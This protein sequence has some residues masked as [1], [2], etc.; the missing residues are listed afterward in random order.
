VWV[1][2]EAQVRGRLDDGSRWSVAVLE[3]LLVI[4]QPDVGRVT[5]ADPP[6]GEEHLS[7]LVENEWN[8]T[9]LDFG[10][11]LAAGPPAEGEPW[12]LW[13]GAP[14]AD[15][16]TGTIALFRGA[17]TAGSEPDLVLEANSPGDRLGTVIARCADLTGDGRAEWLAGAPRYSPP[18]DEDPP[19]T[20]ASLAGAVF[21]LE[22]ERLDL[23]DGQGDVR[24]AGRVWW[25]EAVGEGVG[26][27]LACDHDVTG[28][29]VADVVVGAPRNGSGREGSVFVL[30]GADLP[31]AGPIGSAATRQITGIDTEGWFGVSLVAADFDRDERAELAVGAPGA[32][33]GTG[34]VLLYGGED[35]VSGAGQIAPR[36]TFDLRDRE[37]GR[38]LG[39]FLTSGDID[40]NHIPDL[41]VGA[42]D[43]ALPNAHD[44]GRLFIWQG[45]AKWAGTEIAG[46]DNQRTIEGG[47]PYQRVGRTA[48]FA[49]LDGDGDDDLLLPTR[50]SSTTR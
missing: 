42:P 7:N 12:D 6:Q 17:A 11:A 36:T 16:D 26:T 15:A 23:L 4:G 25:G 1:G 30:S 44:A 21:L 27:S 38:H 9:T 28:D 45:G 35:L 29:G 31:D 14:G 8:A 22:S 41:L 32:R 18:L 19:A 20:S 33:G 39:R 2:A 43:W 13:V 49:D 34:S 40:G 10:L 48:F 37:P 3:G 24:D 5:L 47:R 46:E 50:D